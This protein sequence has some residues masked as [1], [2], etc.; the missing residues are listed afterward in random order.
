MRD[1]IYLL[2]IIATSCLLLIVLDN[3]YGLVISVPITIITTCVLFY[4][5]SRE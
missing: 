3:L 1:T 5:Y 4:F 2:A